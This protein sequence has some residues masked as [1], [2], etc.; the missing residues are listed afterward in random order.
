MSQFASRSARRLVPRVLR[1]EGVPLIADVVVAACH[2]IAP[3]EE[4]G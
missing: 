3:G 2:G 4:G 1:G